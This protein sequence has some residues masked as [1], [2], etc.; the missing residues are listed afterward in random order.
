VPDDPTAR[1]EEASDE[2]VR[3]H[4]EAQR[5]Y[6]A[7][8]YDAARALFERALT[9]RRA[10][11]GE[12]A[13]PTAE[14]LGALAL[15]RAAQGDAAAAQTMIERVLTVR[16]RV[17]GPDHP[18]T[19]EALNNLGAIRRMQGDNAAARRLYERALAIRER[20]LGPDDP[21]TANTLSNLGVTAAAQGEHAM[22]RQYHER[23][24]RIYEHA[25]GPDDL[26]TSRA[27]NNLAALLADQGDLEAARPLLERS[28]AIHE[29]ALGP[30]HPSV[31]NVMINL[32]DVRK[33]QRD[34][35]AA[36]PLYA[37]ALVIRERALGA[38]HARTAEAAAKLLGALSML[39]EFTLALPLKRITDALARTPG[40][41][42]PA[43][44]A[45]LHDFVDRIEAQLA[46]APHPPADQRALDEAA[47]MQARADA[48]LARQDFAAAQVAIER[49][50]AL[51]A[52]V[53][54]PDDFELVPLLR[55]LALALQAQGE[56]DRLRLLQ[57][58]IV[59]IHRGA[60]GDDH[61]MTL[62]AR[63]QLLGMQVA[64][65]GQTA[66]MPE[67][68]DLHAALLRQVTPDHPLAHAI[69]DTSALMERLKALQ[70]EQPPAAPPPPAAPVL[71]ATVSALLAGLDDVPWRTLR[72]AYGPATD[73]PGQ[74]SALLAPDAP[75]R[76]R[77]LHQLYGN[78][79][80]QGTVYEA[81]SYSV[82]FL[83]KLVG[84]PGTPDRAAILHL[85]AALAGDG[86]PSAQADPAERASHDAVGAALPLYLSLLDPT[87]DHGLR[88]AAIAVVAAFPERA[89]ESV[90]PL[91][92]ALAAER[93]PEVRWW[94]LWALGQVVA[95]G[96][97]EQA[98]FADVLARADDPQMA[99]L[100]ATALAARAGATTPQ[101]ALDALVEAVGT[102]GASEPDGD[103]SDLDDAMA[104]LGLYQWPGVVELAVEQLAQLDMERAQ[105]ALL[106]ALQR[107]RD[108]DAARMVAEGLLDLAFSEGQPLPKPTAMSK[109]PDGRLQ[110]Q[111]WG[112]AHQPERAAATLT[113]DQRAVLVALAAQDSF[114]AQEHDLLALYGLPATREGLG[115]F[116]AAEEWG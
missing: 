67:M 107:T 45:A 46:R 88:A 90:P 47:Q 96:A 72:H 100:A 10:A 58:R 92:A 74:I 105:P 57:E 14:T 41:P 82:P 53:L 75:T 38:A 37:R 24:L 112:R 17:L 34:Y 66:A 6:D 79:W 59:A 103:G 11:L 27:L 36:R 108:G 48:L 54:G 91:Q 3:L 95:S 106:R 63:T 60:L 94:L 25:L 99:F 22:A 40:Q 51:R 104:S 49:A 15:V 1:P 114:W 23:A 32:A 20:V 61:P 44:V 101:P 102:L 62:A 19:A 39:R 31:A 68:E 50:L 83:I 110:V 56:Y 42:D 84:H 77:A 109:R 43:T 13:L 71:P 64:D 18:E 55:Q 8:A 87:H 78:I 70:R 81:S 26:K 2:A 29:R 69:R 93:A 33:L 111:Y 80:H 97:P 86:T 4:D 12:N 5:Q 116:L 115:A 73:V 65:E 7:G 16:E 21:L 113:D 9:L 30:A 35:A 89:A 52:G 85:L 28:L 98:Y 76:E